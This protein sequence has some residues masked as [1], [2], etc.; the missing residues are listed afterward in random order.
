MSDRWALIT[1]ADDSW[2]GVTVSDAEPSPPEDG[3]QYVVRVPP[4]YPNDKAWSPA[5]KGFTDR[6]VAIV[7]TLITVGRFKLLLTKAERVTIRTAAES[8]AD[9]EDFLDLLAGFTDGVSL[10][11]PLLIGA[12]AELQ[13]AGL[14]TADRVT[15]ILA[16]QTP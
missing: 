12:L 14:L 5:L 8:S 9:V 15:A 1:T 3:S 13:A 2:D 6:A 16:G 10:A 11:D 7:D 4:S